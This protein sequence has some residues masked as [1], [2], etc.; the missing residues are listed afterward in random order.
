MRRRTASSQPYL[1]LTQKRESKRI[2]TGHVTVEKRR[3]ITGTRLYGAAAQKFVVVMM[4]MQVT[5]MPQANRYLR[6]S[7]FVVRY[8]DGYVLVHPGSSVIL[9]T[10]RLGARAAKR[11]IH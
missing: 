10:D 1:H 6:T 2:S 4:R 3:I 9:I 11:L 5:R 8:R 7:L